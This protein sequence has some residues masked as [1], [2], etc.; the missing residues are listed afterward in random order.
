VMRSFES[1][2]PTPIANM[3]GVR[4]NAARRRSRDNGA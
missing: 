3:R 1:T 2:R 4:A